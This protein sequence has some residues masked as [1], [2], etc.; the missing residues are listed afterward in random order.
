M[1]TGSIC[2][3][4]RAIVAA[5]SEAV[6]A[7]D[8]GEASAEVL[9]PAAI[10]VHLLVPEIQRGDIAEQEEIE[11]L[12]ILQRLWKARDGPGLDRD[13]LAP[14]HIGEGLPLLLIAIHQ[15]HA[16]LAP[17]AGGGGGAVVL[18]DGIERRDDLHFIGD[19][20]PVR[21]EI[22]R[23][24]FVVAGLDRDVPLLDE[25]MVL[26]QLHFAGGLHVAA[27]VA[28]EIERLPLL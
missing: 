15:Q 23:A 4:G 19:E 8:H 13:L 27:D 7:A 12:Q 22:R 6:F 9:H 2:S 3:I 16:R 25:K 17:Q 1:R 28:D 26:I 18:S 10:E 24:E 11:L 21:L 14:Q 5:D 20:I